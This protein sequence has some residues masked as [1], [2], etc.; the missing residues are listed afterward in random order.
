MHSEMQRPEP[1]K[2][3]RFVETLD[4]RLRLETLAY[5]R[6]YLPPSIRNLFAKLKVLAKPLAQS[7]AMALTALVIIVAISATPAARLGVPI[8][9]GTTP[10]AAPSQT[11]LVD[12]DVNY[13]DYLPAG[14]LL[15]IRNADI[16][17]IG[18]IAAE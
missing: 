6:A 8:S 3:D 4:S 14:D 1:P 18:S 12:S 17:D 10:L 16:S 13:L 5:R 7:G 15:A 2:I 9:S 11:N